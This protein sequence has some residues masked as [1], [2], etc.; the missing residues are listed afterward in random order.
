[1]VEIVE[2]EKSRPGIYRT[3]DK[4]YKYSGMCVHMWILNRIFLLD[5]IFGVQEIVKAF[6]PGMNKRNH[7]VWR[8]I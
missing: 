5:M 7:R 4:K 8:M 3:Y 6:Y 1:M 2:P